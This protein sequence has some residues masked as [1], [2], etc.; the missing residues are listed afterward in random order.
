MRKN[1]KNSLTIF[2]QSHEIY[3]NDNHSHQLALP[4]ASPQKPG[5][6]HRKP[7]IS[8]VPGILLKERNR[9]RVMLGDE[10]LGDNLAIDQAIALANQST[11]H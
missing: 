3:N 1:I 2:S 6:F 4:L 5:I 10:I 8:S 11:H 9:Y 7:Q